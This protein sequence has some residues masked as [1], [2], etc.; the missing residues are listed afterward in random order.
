MGKAGLGACSLQREFF[1]SAVRDTVFFN[2]LA[3]VTK[4]CSLERIQRGVCI[5]DASY[6]SR[7]EVHLVWTGLDSLHVNCLLAKIDISIFNPL[8]TELNPIY[9]L[10]ALLGAHHILHVSRI[11]VNKKIYV[12]E[13][14]G[15]SISVRV[16][17]TA[18]SPKEICTIR[19]FPTSYD[20]SPLPPLWKRDHCISFLSTLCITPYNVRAFLH[21]YTNTLV[22]ALCYFPSLFCFPLINV[23]RSPSFVKS[24]PS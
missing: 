6:Q 2:K 10:L 24:T 8:N 9:P 5:F 1:P 4:K 21:L 17:V 3:L 11:R 13:E 20:Q 16:H 7:Q 14:M 23:S 12:Y 18:F 22:E 15:C 19:G